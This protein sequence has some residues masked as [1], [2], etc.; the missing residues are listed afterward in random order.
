MTETT[1]KWGVRLPTSDPF[2][3]GPPPVVAGARCAEDLGFDAAW[4]GDHLIACPPVLDAFCC[5]SAAAAVTSRAE[6]G[7]NVLQLGLRQ[8][9]WAA[10]QLATIEAL[11]PGRLRLWVGAGG[12]Y[13]DEFSAAGA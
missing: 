1:V 13:P 2:G 11:A 7:I 3:S 12:E 10:K 6:L 9:A 8:P 5:L 4:V